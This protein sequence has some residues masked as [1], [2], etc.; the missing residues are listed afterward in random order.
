MKWLLYLVI[1]VFLA[2]GCS[3]KKPDPR[4]DPIENPT[5]PVEDW[6]NPEK[7]QWSSYPI[8]V[9]KHARCRMDCRD[10]SMEEVKDAIE[11]GQINYKKS[12]KGRDDKCPM[13]YAFER[14]TK[15]NKRIRVVVAACE[16]ENVIVTVINLDKNRDFN[17]PNDCK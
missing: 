4:Q 3:K 13:K 8:R 14:R 10:I 12:E 6:A 11:N 9:S 17:C 16:T 2:G 7:R 5:I 1:F 15:S